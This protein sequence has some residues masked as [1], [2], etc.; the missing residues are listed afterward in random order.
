MNVEIKL[1]I[2]NLDLQMKEANCLLYLDSII[3]KKISKPK[4]DDALKS[5]LNEFLHINNSEWVV[6]NL[7]NVEN[8]D[9]GIY[10]SYVCLIPQ[11][12]KNKKGKWYKIGT[13]PNED[14]KNLVF[15]ASQKISTTG[16]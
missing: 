11:I 9:K 15:L 3:S 6:F 2:L 4:I 13:I 12:I 7:V 10:I 16:C 14:V 5:L 8:D 1:I